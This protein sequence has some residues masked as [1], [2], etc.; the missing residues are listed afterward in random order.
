MKW[1]TRTLAAFGVMAAAAFGL[2]AYGRS[3]WAA[4][5]R[6]QRARLEAAPSAAD[7]HALRCE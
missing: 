7:A 5:P 1:I 4:A 6:L 3:R 2:A